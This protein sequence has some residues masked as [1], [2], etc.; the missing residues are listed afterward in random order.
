[1]RRALAALTLA[2]VF[3]LMSH[4]GLAAGAD[5]PSAAPD[6]PAS[7]LPDPPAAPGAGDGSDFSPV[8]IPHAPRKPAPQRPD[9]T[10][11]VRPAPRDF[12]GLA[13]GAPLAEAQPKW[14]LEPVKQPFALPDTYMRPA[15]I[16]KLGTADIRSVAYYFRKG[17]LS[18]VG[19]TFEGQIN[20]FLIKDHLIE[21]Y[22]PG[23]QVGDRYG[24]TWNDFNIDLRL[25]NGAGELRYT[26]EP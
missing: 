8:L 21:Q 15:E 7:V 10:F 19:I 18:G 25:N 4:P 6:A 17:R 20:F 2:A 16:L 5:S 24:W 22:G 1:M 11:A 13:W 23:R 14:G 12:R 26:H 9:M 3:N